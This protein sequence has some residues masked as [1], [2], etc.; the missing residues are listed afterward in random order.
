MSP[1]D[2]VWAM[3]RAFESIQEV[4]SEVVVP[5]I[6]IPFSAFALPVDGKRDVPPWLASADRSKVRSRLLVS[7]DCTTAA[8]SLPTFLSLRELLVEVAWIEPVP[9]VFVWM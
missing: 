7:F 8:S 2:L 4:T 5:F 1:V 6:V 9:V 3:R